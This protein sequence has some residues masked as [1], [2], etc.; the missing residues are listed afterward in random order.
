M[1]VLTLSAQVLQAIA[2]YDIL[3]SSENEQGIDRAIVVLT[4][5]KMSKGIRKST[6]VRALRSA[7]EVECP[8]CF[9]S[10]VSNTRSPVRSFNC[11]HVICDKCDAQLYVRADDKCPCCRAERTEGSKRLLAND[12]NGI[13]RARAMAARAEERGTVFFSTVPV[14]TFTLTQASVLF[15]N[16]AARDDVIE[17]SLVLAAADPN[18]RHVVEAL[19]SVG[20]IAEF[21]Q[22]AAALRGSGV[23]RGP[24]RI[25][26][27][28]ASN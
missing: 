20:S 24:I 9:E 17:R 12:A 16:P 27:N 25:P 5:A 11:S 19:N 7:A 23:L 6:R 8:I 21:L 26:G 1:Y 14:E 3:S 2:K 28:S 18:V 22:A 10:T 4:S 15:E 13:A